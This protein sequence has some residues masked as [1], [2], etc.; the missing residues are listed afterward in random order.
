MLGDEATLVPCDLKGDDHCPMPW[1]NCC[2]PSELKSAGTA[3]IQVLDDNGKPARTGIKGVQGLKELSRVTVSGK[4]A[5]NST[6]E[7]FIVNAD[8]IHVGIR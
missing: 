1:D 5:K 4:V 8:A 6:P 7:A 2:D 3:T